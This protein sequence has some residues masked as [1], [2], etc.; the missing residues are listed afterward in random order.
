V[1]FAASVPKSRGNT[2]AGGTVTETMIATKRV[3]VAC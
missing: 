1:T 2:G 3:Q